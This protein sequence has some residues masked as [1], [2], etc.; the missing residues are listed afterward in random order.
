MVK[1]HAEGETIFAVDADGY[2]DSGT[3][4]TVLCACGWTR[5]D[6]RMGSP[7]VHRKTCHYDKMAIQ[8]TAKKLADLMNG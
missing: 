8:E 4:D 1:W 2:R 7:H 3:L 5:L 6:C